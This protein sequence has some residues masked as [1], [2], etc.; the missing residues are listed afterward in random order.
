MDQQLMTPKEVA[1]RLGLAV[2]TLAIWR[3]RHPGRLPYVKL[4]NR[5][6]RY[7]ATDVDA[8]VTNRT[9]GRNTSI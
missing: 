3:C 8:F 1:Q 7:R 6:I 9:V 2:T 5:A 4:G